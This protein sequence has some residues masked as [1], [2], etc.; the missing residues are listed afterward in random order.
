MK[1]SHR[2]NL[3]S[4]IFFLVGAGLSM[5][6]Q[7]RTGQIGDR[8]DRLDPIRCFGKAD[9][10]VADLPGPSWDAAGRKSII[11]VV[12]KNI[13]HRAATGFQ[14]KYSDGTS[15]RTA[16]VAGLAA[17]ATNTI[18]FTVP[19]WVYRPDANYLIQVDPTRRVNEC[20]EKN[21]SKRF[22]NLG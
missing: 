7:A 9:L 22:F 3:L 10:V 15:T 1:L 13:G 14:V 8:P 20:N 2:M 5:T 4:A 21:N 19:Y 16:F 12:V 18:Y 17:G 6:A 11:P